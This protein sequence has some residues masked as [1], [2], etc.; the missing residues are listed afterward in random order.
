MSHSSGEVIAAYKNNVKGL[1]RFPEYD[2][3][4]V[5][6]LLRNSVEIYVAPY[7]EFGH[8]FWLNVFTTWLPNILLFGLIIY[9]NMGARGGGGAFSLGK[10]KAKKLSDKDNVI[11]FNDVAGLP[12]AKSEL[13]EIVDFLKHPDKFIKVGAKIPKG[14]LLYGPP[15]TGKTLLAR[16][17]AGEAK[18]PFLYMSGAEFVEIFVGIGASRVR[19]IFAQAKKYGKCIIFIDELDSIGKKR[20]SMST[21][22]ER[23]NTLNQFLVEM[24]GF[25]MNSGIIVIGATN[26]AEVLD[27]ALLRPG[28]FDR[29][30]SVD[31]PDA[32]GREEILRV[33][34]SKVKVD[35]VGVNL[36]DIIYGSVGM[37]GAELADLVNRA[38]IIAARNA[39]EFILTE[40]LKM[41]MEELILGSKSSII[42]QEYEKKLTAYHEA[43]HAII[44]LN[45]KTSH[46]IFKATIIPTGKAL[47][48]VVRLPEKDEISFSKTKLLDDICV[49]MGGRCAEEITFGQDAITSG[50]AS[51]IK[52]ATNIASKMVT[53]WGMSDQLGSVKYNMSE[54][55]ILL[56]GGSRPSEDS[57][58]KI[59]L[60]IRNIITTQYNRA[61]EIL[62]ANSVQYE[63]L[64]KALLAYETLSGEQVKH[65]IEFDN[66][67]DYTSI[68]KESESRYIY[69]QE[70]NNQEADEDQISED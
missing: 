62:L 40:D 63:R 10:S 33:H 45:V 8:I 12:E 21:N 13:I 67:D 38:A 48:M 54:D 43:G 61:K 15:G 42:M 29:L 7:D 32:R 55:S 22:E 31:L 41:A 24:D 16:A 36:K 6:R 20:S 2:R 69:T 4:F 57:L 18:V 66:L 68:A 44:S 23:E 64:A 9:A 17:I 11:T 53:E 51:D 5:E 26:R 60:E 34:L 50:A 14:V 25:D 58:Q 65:V 49:A 46:P 59:D 56:Y 52:A 39:R 3:D 1:I 47:G 37:S 30:I 70:T 35:I 27:P 19:D 28:R